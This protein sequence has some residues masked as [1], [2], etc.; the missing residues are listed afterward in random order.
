MTCENCGGEQDASTGLCQLCGYQVV[1][2]E[3]DQDKMDKAVTSAPSEHIPPI[4]SYSSVANTGD[5]QQGAIKSKSRRILA[6]IVKWVAVFLTIAVVRGSI[7][8]ITQTIAKNAGPSSS[9]ANMPLAEQL[10]TVST[11]VNKSDQIGK[12][13]DEYTK[14]LST[15]TSGNTFVYHY[16]VS[17]MES[18]ELIDFVALRPS[19]AQSTCSNKSLRTFMDEGTTITYSYVING[20]NEEKHMDIN[21]SDCRST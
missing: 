17:G 2:T 4:S 6:T 9:Y 7:Q 16:S 13:V 5:K 19:V 12:Q 21:A 18:L 14:M 10:S 11:E 8:T 15:S 1:N 3:I 20:T